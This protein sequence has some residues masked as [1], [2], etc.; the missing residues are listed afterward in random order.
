MLNSTLYATIQAQNISSTWEIMAYSC[1]LQER[2]S[3]TSACDLFQ[4]TEARMLCLPRMITTAGEGSEVALVG[5]ATRHDLKHTAV[6]C[7]VV[8]AL[9][10]CGSS[11]LLRLQGCNFLHQILHFTLLQNTNP[12]HKIHRP[13]NTAIAMTT[14]NTATMMAKFRQKQMLRSI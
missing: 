4:K 2:T 12:T 1:A 8:C 10:V 3:L 5:H 13:T 11:R 14:I 9:L 6:W 7:T